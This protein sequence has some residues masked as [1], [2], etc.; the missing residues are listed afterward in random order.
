MRYVLFVRTDR[1]PRTTIL[2]A[3]ISGTWSSGGRGNGNAS[4]AHTSRACRKGLNG[5][6][7]AL[8]KLLVT[9]APSPRTKEWIAGFD[10]L[11]C[12]SMAKRWRSAGR[13]PMAR[14]G[15]IESALPLAHE[16]DLQPISFGEERGR[17]GRRTVV[18]EDVP[19]TRGTGR[20]R[21]RGLTGRTVLITGAARGIG[22]ASARRL[23]SEGAELVLADLDGRGVEK[24]AAELGQVAVQGRRHAARTTSRAW[25]TSPT[26]AGAG[27]T[28]SSTTR[29]SSACSP[30]ST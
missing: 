16:P 5:P 6:Q 27:S 9:K 17:D 19:A 22:A 4:S 13:H 26:S 15:R 14:F 12:D 7:T 1:W 30:C 21:W 8:G 23:A 24:L 10:L 25:W 2:Q 11:E 29:A 18:R 28:C 20:T 3:T